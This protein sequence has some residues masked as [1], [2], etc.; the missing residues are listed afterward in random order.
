MN[1]N[2]LIHDWHVIILPTLVQSHFT[3]LGLSEYTIVCRKHLTPNL[4]CK[5]I[6]QLVEN[7]LLQDWYVIFYQDWY[8][9]YF[10]QIIMVNGSLCR[11]GMY[12]LPILEPNQNWHVTIDHKQQKMVSKMCQ[13]KHT[14]ISCVPSAFINDCPALTFTI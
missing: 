11:T 1:K 3:K 9:L 7:T 5:N 14:C 10:V 2:T 12:F 4:A 13:C 6:L 8:T